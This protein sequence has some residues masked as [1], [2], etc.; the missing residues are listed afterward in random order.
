MQ[1]LALSKNTGIDTDRIMRMST[2][3]YLA[4]HLT[5]KRLYEHAKSQAE[6]HIKNKKM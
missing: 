3:E 1:L 5:E 2:A 6:K 4:L